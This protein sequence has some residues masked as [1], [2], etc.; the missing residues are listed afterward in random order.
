MY[1]IGFALGVAWGFIV[2]HMMGHGPAIYRLFDNIV[3]R[4]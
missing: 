2:L 4:F 1:H 3:G